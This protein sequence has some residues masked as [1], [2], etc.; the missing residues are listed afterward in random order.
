MSDLFISDD[1]NLSPNFSSVSETRDL[2]FSLSTHENYYENSIFLNTDNE[3][4]LLIVE[5]NSEIILDSSNTVSLFDGSEFS[6]SIEHGTHDL[7]SING[8]IE[9]VQKNGDSLLYV[10]DFLNTSGLIKIETGSLTIVNADT[11]NRP[12][13]PIIQNGQLFIG[14]SETNYFIETNG[15]DN[16]E[17]LFRTVS[18]SNSESLTLV[19]KASDTPTQIPLEA[20][21]FENGDVEIFSENSI[22]VAGYLDDYKISNEGIDSYFVDGL[23]FEVEVANIIDDIQQNILE[24]QIGLDNNEAAEMQNSEVTVESIIKVSDYVDLEWQDAIEII[25]DV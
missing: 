3:A 21:E 22:D 20:N 13:E 18:Q 14:G 23:S 4:E 7:I 25:S 2:Q 5:G 6:V 10:E 1:L 24:L 19:G 8:S 11:F 15:Q 12:G 17:I 16:V 9:V